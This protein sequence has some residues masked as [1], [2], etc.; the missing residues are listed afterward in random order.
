MARIFGSVAE[1]IGRTP[2]VRLGRLGQGLKADCET[3][4]PG[5]SPD[6]LA[7][8]YDEGFVR[9]LSKVRGEDG[10]R[11][12]VRALRAAGLKTAVVTNSPKA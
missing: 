4:F 9:H 8:E 1:L 5:E 3:L 12:T 7:R 2:L 11:E 6:L 10:V